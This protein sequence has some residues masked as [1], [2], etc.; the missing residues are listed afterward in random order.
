MGHHE[1]L[2]QDVLSAEQYWKL[3]HA[4]RYSLLQLAALTG[5][6]PDSVKP[7]HH[8]QGMFYTAAYAEWERENDGAEKMRELMRIRAAR[9]RELR[10]VRVRHS[11]RFQIRKMTA[12]TY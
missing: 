6:N 9:L 4:G 1:R 11:I 12:W 8:R 7:L 2:C 10:T 3:L 5:A